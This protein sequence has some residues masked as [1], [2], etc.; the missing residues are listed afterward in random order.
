MH[1]FIIQ[2]VIN[3]LQHSTR[4]L[5]EKKKLRPTAIKIMR[6]ILNKQSILKITISMISFKICYVSNLEIICLLATSSCFMFG[7]FN[8]KRKS[9]IS[10]IIFFPHFS[11][12]LLCTLICLGPV[13]I[14]LLLYPH[15]SLNLSSRHW[16]FPNGQNRKWNQRMEIWIQ[17]KMMT[18]KRLL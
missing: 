9:Q 8:Q 4:W 2:W 16:A 10:L 3:S 15:G 14:K 5:T 13:L 17:E 11:I 1:A 18:I 7:L 6:V 12:L